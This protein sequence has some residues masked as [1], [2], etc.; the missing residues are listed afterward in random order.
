M[1]PEVSMMNNTFGRTPVARKV[2][3]VKT[4]ESSAHA[5][6]ASTATTPTKTALIA[7]RRFMAWVL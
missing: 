3:F 4:S 5:G 6:A 1:E 7:E 2:E